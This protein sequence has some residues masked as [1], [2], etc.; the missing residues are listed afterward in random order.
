MHPHTYTLLC[1]GVCL[2]GISCDQVPRP[3]SRG[4]TFT[5]STNTNDVRIASRAS[6]VGGRISGAEWRVE[7]AVLDRQ[8]RWDGFSSDPPLSVQRAC[9]LAFPDVQRRFPELRDWA[10][11]SVHLRNLL[12]ADHPPELFSFPNVWAYEVT[13]KPKD[14]TAKERLE[15]DYGDHLLTQVVLLDGTVVP[16]RELKE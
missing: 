4:I 14:L 10:V 16:S 12:V 9:A 15:R 6:N 7:R 1:L 2:L 11:H 8:P 3:P 5:S 13:F